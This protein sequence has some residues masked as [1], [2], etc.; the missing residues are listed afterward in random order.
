[1]ITVNAMVASTHILIPIQSSYF[2]LEGTDDLLE[3]ID[4]IKARPNPNL[5]IL[6]VVITLHDKRTVLGKDVFPIAG[7]VTSF[8]DAD[9]QS[10]S[11]ESPAPRVHFTFAPRS[12]GAAVLLPC[13][14]VHPVSKRR[15]FQR[16]HQRPTPLR[17]S[18]SSVWRALGRRFRSRNRDQPRPAPRTS[19][20]GRAP[21]VDRV[22]RSPRA[23][24]VALPDGISDHRGGRA[25]SGPPS[26]GLG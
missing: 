19:R 5:R 23:V 12:S 13:R 14:G 24:L 21:D 17:D 6:G 11:R 8:Q 9:L 25:S 15:A 26:S 2:A 18:L 22:R 1:M 20:P 4:K 7:F 3:T 10:G 16:Y